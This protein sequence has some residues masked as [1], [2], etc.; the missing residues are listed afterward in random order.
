MGHTVLKTK[1]NCTI[2]LFFSVLNFKII[3][4]LHIYISNFY[5]HI[6]LYNYL[7]NVSYKQQN[8]DSLFCEFAS[9]YPLINMFEPVTFNI[10][11][12]S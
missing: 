4:I 2:L 11:I 5:F 8:G 9:F 10:V 3:S 7:L 6:F 12:L 1:I